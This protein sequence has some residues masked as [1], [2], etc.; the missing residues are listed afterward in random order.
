[1]KIVSKFNAEEIRNISGYE[2]AKSFI[3]KL[4][5][6]AA[7]EDKKTIDAWRAFKMVNDISN[8]RL[9]VKDENGE[10]RQITVADTILHKKQVFF[11]SGTPMGKV[12]DLGFE[13]L[14]GDLLKTEKLVCKEVECKGFY[15]GLNDYLAETK[16]ILFMA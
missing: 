1:M 9:R 12:S 14:V 3:D 8:D 7:P 16:K 15:Q 5:S 2:Q 4:Q 10:L 13:K 6:G 11:L